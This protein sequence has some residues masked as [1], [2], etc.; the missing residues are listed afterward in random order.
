MLSLLIAC[1]AF[2]ISISQLLNITYVYV[3][4]QYM[5]IQVYLCVKY[6]TH[7]REFIVIRDNIVYSNQTDTKIPT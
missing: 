3:H 6:F 1:I 7:I 2:Q 4:I 5:Y